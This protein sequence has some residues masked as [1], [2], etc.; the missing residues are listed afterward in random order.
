[1]QAEV[2]PASSVAVARYETAVLALWVT[3]MPP[4]SNV[5]SVPVASA[6]PLQS[7]VGWQGLLRSFRGAGL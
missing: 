6:E 4:A 2:F 5:A 1:M 7:D 3:S